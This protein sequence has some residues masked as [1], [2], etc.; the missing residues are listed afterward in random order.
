M[1][2]FFG[3]KYDRKEL[4]RR[5][6]NISQVAYVC[7]ALYTGGKANGTKAYEVSNGTGLDFSVLESKC[8]DIASMKYRGVNLNYM[9]KAGITAPD[10]ADM[11]GTE[12]TRCINGGMLYTCGLHNVG[13][14][15]EDNGVTEVFH[16][17]LKTTPAD[18][19]SISTE[20]EGD[21]YILRLSGEVRQAAIYNE[22]LVLKRT[23]TAKAGSKSVKIKDIVENQG[24]TEQGMMLLYHVNSGF[25][26]LDEGSRLIIPSKNIKA[27]DDI[28]AKGINEYSNI[29]APIDG[30][31]EHVFFHEVA[32]DDS[33]FS[34]AAVINDSLGIGL[35]IRYNT[36]NLPRLVQ[37]KS[38]VSGDYALGIMPSTG[39]V[40][41]RA[42]EKQ[43]G[44]LK[45]IAPFEKLEF[46]LEIGVLDG[47]E[48][49][50]GFESYIKS[51]K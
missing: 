41:G 15:C 44:K 20:W 29:T 23:I 22:N 16:G 21:D 40:S 4:L 36:A 34:G 25:P 43:N 45:M 24:F 42:Y 38:M 47:A 49:I 2:D 27:R 39:Y 32:C 18:N 46:G 1:A 8:L 12:F 7:P 17:N 9:F 37:W 30:F 35:Y 11:H 51:L 33:G 6:G 48:D 28:S 13:S 50:R 26:L 31:T 19:V 14:P 3:R 5:T 10:L